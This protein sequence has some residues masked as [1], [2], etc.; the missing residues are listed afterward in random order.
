MTAF[1]FFRGPANA[2]RLRTLRL[3]LAELGLS[4]D[5]AVEDDLGCVLVEPATAETARLQLRLDNDNGD[6]VRAIGVLF[7]DGLFGETAL[8]KFYHDFDP[9]KPNIDDASGHFWLI[10]KKKGRLFLISDKLGTCKIHYDKQKI[11]FSNTF[12]CVAESLEQP[13]TDVQACFEY[14]WNGAIFGERTLLEEAATVPAEHVVEVSATPEVRPLPRVALGETE[15]WDGDIDRLVDVHIERERRVFGHYARWFGDDVNLSFSGGYDSRLALALLLDAGIT[16]RIFVNGH[17]D[18]LDCRVAQSVTSG[19]NL[20]LEMFDNSQRPVIPVEDYAAHLGRNYCVLGGW[21][22]SGLFSPVSL[23]EGRA[24]RVAGGV[25][26]MNG[27]LGEIY[28]NFFYLPDHPFSTRDVVWSF[29]SRY[30][31]TACTGRFD[32]ESYEGA[33]IDVMERVAGSPSD[34]QQ[35]R[36]V[37]LIYPLFRGRY[38]TAR[39]VETNLRLGSCLY[40]FMEP[41]VIKGTCDIPIAWKSFGIFEA[42]MIRRLNP[43]LAAYSSDYGFSFAE[44]PPLGYRLKSSLLSYRRPPWLRRLSYRLQYR[45]PRPR[46]YFLQPT[47]LRTV[48]DDG[49]PLMRHLFRPDAINDPEVFNRVATME[50]IFQRLG[51]RVP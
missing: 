36:R 33:L 39:S 7:Y 4:L 25:A 48:L 32:R 45:K 47:Y 24:A 22:S 20:P 49:F 18:D 37:E 19:E 30:D 44:D 51:A 6:Y 9:D 2:R 50:Y 41:A 38:W 13:V 21:N 12:I 43:R 28:R 46:P 26:R 5:V 15:Q 40:P 11:I 8:K 35:R 31:P 42:R 1:L 29:Y 17:K 14:A 34:R 16:P 3:R 23:V 10:V 27:A